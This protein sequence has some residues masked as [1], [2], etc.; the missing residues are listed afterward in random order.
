MPNRQPIYVGYVPRED[1][2]HWT[3]EATI[4]EW[5]NKQQHAANT[6][7]N[8]KY[9]KL[10]EHTPRSFNASRIEWTFWYHRHK[11]ILARSDRADTLWTWRKQIDQQETR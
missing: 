5:V 1:Q 10:T 9:P 11:Y 7:E 2:P 6:Y 8:F 3:P 4:V